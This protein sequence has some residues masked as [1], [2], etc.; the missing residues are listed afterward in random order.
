MDVLASATSVGIVHEASCPDVD[1][2]LCFDE[3]VDI[4]LHVHDQDIAWRRASAAVAVGLGGGW[5]LAVGQP[6]ER[7]EVRVAYTLPDGSPY[8]PP[9]DDIHHRDETLGGLAD[10]SVEVRWYRGVGA[11]TLGLGGGATVPLGRPVANP[12]RL[13]AQGL[14]HEHQQLGAGVPSGL[15]S[16]EAVEGRGRA[17]WLLSANGQVGAIESDEGFRPPHT[18]NV[19]VAPTWRATPTVQV[20]AGIDGAW[21]GADR[22]DGVDYGGRTRVAAT[23][24]I[25]AAVAPSLVVQ[26][27][28]RAPLWQALTE[29]GHAEAEEGSLE[30]AWL[31]SIG[32][33]WT[34][35]R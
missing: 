16:V 34:R 21:T 9:Y 14:R 17:G 26:G 33:S 4:P 1:P 24:G 8:D 19:N 25:I 10:G 15:W 12:W 32:L 35:P 13:T 27:N 6:V 30:E 18:V 3:G 29:H 5:Q 28:A 11:W 31:V 20:L 22:W 7:R 23:A 2:V